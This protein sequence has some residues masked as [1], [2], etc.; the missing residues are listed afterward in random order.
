[1]KAVR[2]NGNEVFSD[3]Q[4]ARVAAPY[5]GRAIATEELLEMRDAMTRFYIDRAML[6]RAPSFPIRT[7]A[8][9]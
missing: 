4:L 3:D 2:F 8:T 9:A 5:T 1:M 7:S 6:I